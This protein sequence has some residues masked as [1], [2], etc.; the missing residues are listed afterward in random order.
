MHENL[1]CCKCSKK[2]EEKR[3]SFSYLGHTFYVELPGCPVCGQV[4][5]DEDLVRG[6][7]A[8]VEASLEDK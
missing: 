4:Y 3:T 2:L 1:V 6:K 5:V 7:M 8:E